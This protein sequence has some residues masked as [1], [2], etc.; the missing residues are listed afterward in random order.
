MPDA[1]LPS[2]RCGRADVIAGDHLHGDA[3]GSTSRYGPGGLRPGRIGHALQAKEGEIALDVVVNQGRLVGFDLAHGK[4]QHPLPL[5]GHGVHSGLDRSGIEGVTVTI[6]AA[7]PAA[8]GQ[9]RLQRAFH[10]NPFTAMQGG[11]HLQFRLKGQGVAAGMLPVGFGM[12]KAGPL[13]GRQ[14]GGFGGIPHQALVAAGPGITAQQA[15]QQQFAQGPVALERIGNG[16]VGCLAIGPQLLQPQLLAGGIE[17]L[18]R[19]AVLGEG[20]GLV[21]ADHRGAAQG[22]HGGQLADD[23]VALGHAAYADGQGDGHDGRQFLRDRTHRQRHGGIKHLRATAASGQAHH[24]RDN[25]QGQHQPQDCEAEAAELAGEGGAEASPLLQRGGQ[26]AQFG[27]ITGGHH[28]TA[29]LP[30]RHEAA[31]MGH[32]VAIRQR[33]LGRIRMDGLGHRQGFA[34]EARFIQLEVAHLQQAKVCRHPIPAGEDH[35]IARHQAL[36]IQ[37]LQLPIA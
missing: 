25:R 13:C 8:A 4:G 7:L 23:R 35:H 14:Q 20:A 24:G 6:A 22:F 9:H 12:V 36:G 31:G 17:L 16:A 29:P 26:V 34:G 2:D 11:H 3:G 15:R 30:G 27:G 5:A 1:H 32:A 18:H 37:A 10:H 19:H 33:G 21:G 28:H